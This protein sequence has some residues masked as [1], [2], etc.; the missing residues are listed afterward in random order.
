[1]E[2]HPVHFSSVNASQLDESLTHAP[3]TENFRHKTPSDSVSVLVASAHP[4]CKHSSAYFPGM[5]R[6]VMK[7]PVL[8]YLHP[9]FGQPVQFLQVHIVGRGAV[10]QSGQRDQPHHLSWFRS[11]V[12]TLLCARDQY[13]QTCAGR[14]GNR[15]WRERERERRGGDVR[16]CHV[17]TSCHVKY[18]SQ[19]RA[20]EAW[21]GRSL[22]VCGSPTKTPVIPQI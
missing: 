14:Q 6:G 2:I 22:V 5:K 12:G 10:E 1:M 19:R 17:R 7:T 15:G 3:S 16:L 11:W 9:R 18:S 20:G 4:R 13:L 21:R 8:L